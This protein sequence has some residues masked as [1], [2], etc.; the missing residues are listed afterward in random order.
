MNYVQLSA[1]MFDKANGSNA[2][3]MTKIF[4]NIAAAKPERLVV[5]FQGGLV[6]RPAALASADRRPNPSS[7]DPIRAA[8]ISQA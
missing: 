5:Y 3:T 4:S 7:S 8:T 6:S 1:G 2:E